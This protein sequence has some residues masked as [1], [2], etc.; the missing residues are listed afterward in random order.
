[1]MPKAR[2]PHIRTVIAAVLLALL[3]PAGF[4]Q[5]GGGGEP[6]VRF[7][8]LRETFDRP[9]VSFAWGPASLL[10]TPEEVV[11]YTTRARSRAQRAAFIRQFWATMALNCPEGENP[12]R[13]L[14]WKR[15]DEAA[16]RFDDEPLPG[17]L[18]DRGR[19]F[20]LLGPPE[21]E[22]IA[23]ARLGRT[24]IEVLAWHWP[25]A[26]DLPRTVVFRRR[27][28]EWFFLDADPAPDPEDPSVLVVEPE[29]FG[30]L[31][32]KLALHF[33]QA[34]ACA[35]TEEQKAELAQTRWRQEL[36]RIADA[37]L[38]DEPTGVE[39]RVEPQW[40]FFPAE[41]GAT[42]FW[43]TIPE[44]VTPD[45][46][47]RWVALLRTEG[48]T[49]RYLGTDDFPFARRE[50]GGGAPA[51]VQAARSV[52]PGRYA[53]VIGL[54]DASG[55]LEPLW[56]GRQ[57]VV[58]LPTDVLRLTSIVTTRSITQL[59]GDAAQQTGPFRFGGFEIVPRIDEVVHHGEEFGV[60][61]QVLGAALDDR[62]R[63]DLTITY[64]F[65][66]R[67][68]EQFVNAGRPVVHEHAFGA[69]HA[70]S[71]PIVPQWPRAAYRLQISVRDNRSGGSVEAS[72]PFRVE[73]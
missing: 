8:S 51:L 45:E 66:I 46:G 3:V 25:A 18:T 43:L 69:T 35:L 32:P 62:G 39:A 30:D 67:R 44:T 27:G 21:R 50:T 10:M 63:A 22:E 34:H 68:G 14:F 55:E 60:F 57:V 2:I 17:W 64:Q 54:A 37:V 4:G 56:A 12:A 61:Y 71:T 65:Q 20:I 73:P 48:E 9:V 33:R 26:D 52:E 36:W 11:L 13:E 31:L 40:A 49:A 1:M 5:D 16:Q 47:Q 6:E 19:L 53:V 72:V 29:R 15:V 41:Q 28:L 7:E 58:R 38:A 59:E 23:T 24:T 70:W 42:F